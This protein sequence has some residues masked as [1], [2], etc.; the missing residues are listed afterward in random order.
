MA[1]ASFVGV[2]V[3]RWPPLDSMKLPGHEVD[4]VETG[5]RAN[6]FAGSAHQRVPEGPSAARTLPHRTM[7]VVAE[8]CLASSWPRPGSP[9]LGASV[10]PGPGEGPLRRGRSAGSG[11]TPGSAGAPSPVPS[12]KVALPVDR[13]GFGLIGAGRQADRAHARAIVHSGLGTIEAVCDAD[14]A[15]ARRRAEQYGLPPER[16]FTRYQDL[17]ECSAVVAV[18]IGTPNHVHAPAAIAAATSGKHVFCEKPI[19]MDTE[20]A[21]R[22]L[23]AVRR[24]RVRHMTAFTY[25]FV[26]AMRYLR[27]VVAAGH[28]GTP[29]ILRSRRLMDWPDESLGWRQIKSQ[30]ASGDLGDMASHRVDYAQSMF[31]P[32]RAVQGLT[33]IFVPERR[34]P[35]GRMHAAEVDDWCAFIAEFDRGV[36]GVFESTKLAR[37]YGQGDHGTDDFEIHGAGGSA[38][39][40]LRDPHVLELGA[41]GG[42]LAPVEV[43]VEFRAPVGT[44]VPPLSAE[45]SLAFRENQMY[46][47]ID[48]VRTGRDCSPNFL[49]GA[50]VVA[51]V[52]AVLRS[53][54]ERRTVDV[55]RVD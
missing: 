29:R 26:P 46:E 24:A 6:D 3:N 27:H 17:L 55:Q 47:F 18:T 31:G 22:M 14:E 41:A 54:T 45:P 1:N 9:G 30:A 5:L 13:I 49:D 37:G 2:T 8:A 20:E 11:S 10:R 28:L 52:D 32:V 12:G 23:E 51:V 25:R 21:L 50:R 16:C 44:G 34:L 33:R 15:L 35:D 4:E 40:R 43:P 42:I 36:V 53:A 39:Y 38:F 7:A 19:A 48:A